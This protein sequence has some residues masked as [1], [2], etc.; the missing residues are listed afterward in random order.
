MCVIERQRPG[1]F[2]FEQG[3]GCFAQR[4]LN[5]C[6]TCIVE[7]DETAVEHCVPVRG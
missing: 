6:T 1:A 2:G 4:G 7:T 5:Q 3:K